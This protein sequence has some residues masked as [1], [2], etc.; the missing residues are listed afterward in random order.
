MKNNFV[1]AAALLV[2]VSA[3]AAGSGSL[4]DFFKKNPDLQKN[5]A[6]RMAVTMQAKAEAFNDSGN[7]VT[8]GES[9]LQAMGDA[10]KRME[11]DGYDYA[12]VG[13]RYIKGLCE[14]DMADM[15]SLSTKDCELI[16]QYKED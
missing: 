12:V 2:S 8:T 4:D 1:V 6:V 7:T 15:Y 5:T 13:I 10:N 3:Y 16:K 14:E 9:A 11:D